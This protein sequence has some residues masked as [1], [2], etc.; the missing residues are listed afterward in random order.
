M[1]KEQ[2]EK[3]AKARQAAIDRAIVELGRAARELA[4]DLYEAFFAEM[5]E[6]AKDGVL[7][8]NVNRVNTST[9]WRNYYT[10]AKSVGVAI[11]K[12]LEE[13]ADTVKDYFADLFGRPQSDFDR[14][15]EQLIRQLGYDGAAFTKGGYLRNLMED[16]SVERR[17]KALAIQ[18]IRA[19]KSL[20]V[21]KSDLKAMLLGSGGKMGIVEADRKS[22]V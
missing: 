7:D 18:A 16:T 13:V 19:G 15:A 11:L 17:V 21:F 2:L 4:T 14:V 22:V 20:T 6:M 9:A 8:G 10:N 3:H 12:S 1:T 5:A